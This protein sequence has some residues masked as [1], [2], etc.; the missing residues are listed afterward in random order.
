MAI[1]INMH[2][3]VQ[4][5]LLKILRFKLQSF[6]Y[7]WSNQTCKTHLLQSIGN[8]CLKNNKIVIYVTS[9]NFITDFVYNLHNKTM[10]NSLYTN[11][12]I[13]MFYS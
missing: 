12:E 5:Q 3:L 4:L 11:I 8:Y 9:E 10:N 1:Q 7:L 6:V 2:I 13:V